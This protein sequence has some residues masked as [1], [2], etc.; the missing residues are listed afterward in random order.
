[1]P[2]ASVEMLLRDYVDRGSEAAFTAVV[3]RCTGLVYSTALRRVSGDAYL[4]RDVTQLVFVDLA[5]KARTL[6]AETVI[7]GWLHHHTCF[8][9]ATLVRSERRRRARE[10]KAAAMERSA[11]ESSDSWERLAPLLDDALESLPC[12]D[13][14]AIVLRFFASEDLASMG[15]S[16]G[17]TD[18]TA[19]K[20]V[21]RA[22][23]KLRRFF[24][25]RG[26]ATSSTGLASV[27]A[28]QAVQG[29]PAG[30]AAAAAQ[31]ALLQAAAGTGG[32]LAALATTLIMGA[33]TKIAIAAS[34]A[35]LAVTTIVVQQQENRQLRTELAD[36]RAARTT[37]LSATA[38][39]AAPNSPVSVEPRAIA[40]APLPK[41]A[42]SEV[43]EVM[44]RVI[45]EE[46]WETDHAAFQSLLSRIKGR[47]L[48]AALAYAW[49]NTSGHARRNL[50][51]VVVVHWTRRDPATVAGYVERLSST[52]RAVQVARDFAVVWANQVPV[53]AAHWSVALP[54]DS[55]QRQRAIK[56]VA[57]IWAGS[58]PL[59]AAAWASQLP[60]GGTRDAAITTIADVWRQFDP[61]AARRWVTETSLPDEAKQA[62]L[63]RIAAAP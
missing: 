19:Q 8:R 32:G 30:I 57:E 53:A 60:P 59:P 49:A 2:D 42:A 17:V 39:P 15:R 20:R 22:L 31:T 45:R 13:R 14:D 1:M 55:P 37:D 46:L 5:R 16:W 10:E 29:A 12:R 24:A 43:E 21:S 56:G 41:F 28:T 40:A 18:D 50:R 61:D 9:A 62:L 47:D 23:E 48:P 34:F 52:K 7:A 11:Q 58:D 33:K 51:I 36:A 63:K 4:A 35:A 25:R 6:S 44:A 26:V 54:N 38:E 27:M 3:D